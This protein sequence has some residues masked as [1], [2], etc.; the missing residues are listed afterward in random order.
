M[1][2]GSQALQEGGSLL[3]LRPANTELGQGW[4]TKL[5]LDPVA[6]SAPAQRLCRIRPGP[7]PCG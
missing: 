2:E 6:G 1:A 3:S 5:W 4:S 7:R